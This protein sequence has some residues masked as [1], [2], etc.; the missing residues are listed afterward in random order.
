MISRRVKNNQHRVDELNR[1]TKSLKDGQGKESQ[2][3]AIRLR[4][5]PCASVGDFHLEVFNYIRL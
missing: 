2:L 1:R 4:Y 3:E 5:H